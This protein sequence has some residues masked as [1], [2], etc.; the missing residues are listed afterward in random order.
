M[1]FYE[2]KCLDFRYLGRDSGRIRTIMMPGNGGVQ[3]L[4][5]FFFFCFF[6]DGG[7]EFDTFLVNCVP[8]RMLFS[9]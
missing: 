2:S 1:F 9:Y 8:F 4:G 5:V 7:F 3:L 6:G